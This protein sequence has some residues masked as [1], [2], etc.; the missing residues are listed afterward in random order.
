MLIHISTVAQRYKPAYCWMSSTADSRRTSVSL[1][2]WSADLTQVTDV[3]TQVLE[4]SSEAPAIGSQ[5]G[6]LQHKHHA[7]HTVLQAR[8]LPLEVYEPTMA[9]FRTLPENTD[10]TELMKLDFPEPTGP[11]INTRACGGQG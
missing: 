6:S 2:R 3:F 1:S 11:R 9:W 10:W 5:L 7:V 8:V 4:G